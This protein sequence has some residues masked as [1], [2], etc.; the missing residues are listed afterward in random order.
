MHLVILPHPLKFVSSQRAKALSG[1][2]MFFCKGLSHGHACAPCPAEER[3]LGGQ[4]LGLLI[5]PRSWGS[6]LPEVLLAG[7]GEGRWPSPALCC[8][9]QLLPA[10]SLPSQPIGRASGP[11]WSRWGLP[12]GHGGPRASPCP[13]AA[14]SRPAPEPSPPPPPPR[15]K[16]DTPENTSC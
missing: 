7:R 3:W 8:R 16:K 1:A 2:F 9:T 4:P 10:R 14:F 5:Y 13:Q 15:N 12:G 11:A 6:R